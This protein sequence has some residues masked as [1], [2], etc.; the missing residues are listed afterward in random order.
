MRVLLTGDRGYLGEV[1]KRELSRC[2]LEIRGCDAGW[3]DPPGTPGERCDFRDLGEGELRGFDA[4]VHLA[5]V[6]NDASGEI[7]ATATEELNHAATTEF[8]RAARNAG[9]RSFVLASSCSVYGAAGDVYADEHYAPEPLTAY[10]ASKLNAERDVLALGGPEFGATALRFATLYGYS[11]SFRSDLMVNRMV[12]TAWRFGRI[13]TSG[14]GAAIRPMLHVA[15]AAAAICATVAG[16]PALV[17][18]RIFNVGRPGENFRVSDVADLVSGTFPEAQIVNVGSEDA[19]TYSVAFDRFTTTFPEW[20]PRYRPADG[21][22]D[23]AAAYRRGDLAFPGAD[24]EGWG[25]TDRRDHLL[26]LVRSAQ[27]DEHFRRPSQLETGTEPLLPQ[28]PSGE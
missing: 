5:A 8:A 4:V 11:P 22:A 10:G 16:D 12:S 23:V 19:R 26:A 2:G 7:V 25:T 18:G 13:N 17:T 3:F 1:T 6:C 14:T 15:D 24:P 28:S 9:I 20:R 21:V 27:L